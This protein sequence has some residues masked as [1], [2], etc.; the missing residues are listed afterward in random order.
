MNPADSPRIPRRLEAVLFDMDGVLVDSFDAWVA[1]VEGCRVRRGLAPVGVEAVRACWG[2]GIDADCE[3][4]F[5]GEDPRRLAI[6]YDG[7]FPRHLPLVRA[8]EGALETVRAI[9]SAGLRTAVVTNTPAVLAR[10]IVGEVGLSTH[11]DCLAGG[12]EVRRG[13][14]D[15]E[16]IFLALRRLGSRPDRAVLIGDTRMDLE[17]ARASGVAMIGYRIGDGDARVE[18]MAEILP[19]LGLPELQ[20]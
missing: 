19:L 7:E 16:I 8:E 14:P 12:D 9:A 10:R 20:R 1:V 2:Q 18:R 3:T 15:P 4:L 17:A 5:P 13:K 11:F 6:E